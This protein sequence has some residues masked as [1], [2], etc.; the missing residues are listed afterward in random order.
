MYKCNHFILEELVSKAVIDKYGD[1]A[2]SFLD[3]RLLKTL[4]FLREQLGRPITIN[5]WK[6]EGEFS[7]RGLRENTCDIVK[8]KTAQGVIY[9][10]GHVLGIAAD[11]DVKGMTAG[12]VRRWIV[13][14]QESLPYPV[15]LEDKA[16]WVH[17]DV[18]ETD[19]QVYIFNA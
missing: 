4:D 19:N 12:E 6:W 16:S 8:K 10:S 1:K 5:N 7:Q 15:R 14:N 3:P 13:E 9:L 11:F 2:W 17:L 18:L